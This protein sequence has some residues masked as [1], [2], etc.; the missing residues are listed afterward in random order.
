MCNEGN[1]QSFWCNQQGSYRHGAQMCTTACMQVGMAIL[2]KQLDPSSAWQAALRRDQMACNAF[3]QTL[4]WCMNT[5]SI[6]HGRIESILSGNGFYSPSR[7]ISVNELITVLKIDLGALGVRLDELVLCKRGVDTRLLVGGGGSSSSSSR[8]AGQ[9]LYEPEH[10]FVTLSHL[11]L[12]MQ[13]TNRSKPS[14]ALV[15]A[16]GHTLCVAFCEGRFALF[17]P[18]PGQMWVGMSGAQLASKVQR[19]LGMPSCVLGNGV[20]NVCVVDKASVGKKKRSKMVGSS[21]ED[22]DDLFYADVTIL[23]VK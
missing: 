23:H 17:D 2:C 14:V 10:C 8:I 11:P 19:M 9:L 13:T 1:E 7:M 3:V 18:M 16:N 20:E 21:K 15:T 5:G 22:E 6:V 4:N 12:C